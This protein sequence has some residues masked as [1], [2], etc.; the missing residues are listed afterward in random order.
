MMIVSMVAGS[1][2]PYACVGVRVMMMVVVVMMMRMRC[3]STRC[4]HGRVGL[5]RHL[6]MQAYRI[7]R[8]N[9][10]RHDQTQGD[11]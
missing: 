11:Q 8:N 4:H 5:M 3:T 7:I 6:H 1:G 9:V 2:T 10:N